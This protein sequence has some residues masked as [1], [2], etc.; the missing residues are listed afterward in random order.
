MDIII[1]GAG[2]AGLSTAL[3]LHQKCD[4]WTITVLERHDTLQA[5]G[6]VIGIMPSGTKVLRHLGLLDD[7]WRVCGDRKPVV[8]WRR[9]KDGSVLMTQTPPE[10]EEMFGIRAATGK[11]ADFQKLLYDAA[12]KRGIA[13]RFNQYV[14]DVDETVPT[15]TL[16]TGEVIT[17][18]LIIAADGINSATR[19]T[20]DPVSF[21][22][23][24]GIDDYMTSIPCS[25]LEADPALQ[26]LL[27][28]ANLWWG[29]TGCVIAGI[30]GVGSEERY[31]AEF[32]NINGNTGVQGQWSQE[33][34]IAELRTAFADW[35][36]TLQALLGHVESA[37]IWHLAYTQ[38]GLDWVSQS[39]K[40][41]LIG[42][43]A[44][45]MLPH[46]MAG[47]TTAIEDGA[48][49]AE[50]LSRATSV[51][52]IPRSLRAFAAIRRPR[53]AYIQSEGRNRSKMFHLPDGPAQQA[54]DEMFKKNPMMGAPAWDGKH[55]DEPPSAKQRHLGMPYV[56]GHE[57]IDYTNRRLDDIW[58][59][60]EEALEL[61]ERWWD[62]SGGDPELVSG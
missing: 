35:D 45:A 41:V 27:T 54:R 55:I 6:S 51:A 17:A 31:Y 37:K 20:L 38:M 10:R 47:A 58:D 32:C 13:V 23:F 50:C 4:R 24:S 44:H 9:W 5:L 29:P 2:I 16:K 61:K 34:D 42:D 48:S 11:R 53:L 39:G 15:V 59:K 56:V 52:Q 3:S 25:V 60:G 1:I 36:P 33:A 7:V 21:Q 22:T 30:A 62:F 8:N 12:V 26:P 19:R 43:A 46:A 57:A 18:D 28:S 40:V 49:L 14:A